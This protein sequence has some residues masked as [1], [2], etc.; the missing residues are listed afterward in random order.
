[1]QEHLGL[2]DEQLQQMQEI[3]AQGGT[4]EEMHAV[5]TEEQQAKIKER[6]KNRHGD[7]SADQD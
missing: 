5:L 7:K 1:M 2:S 6:H 4:R 3:R